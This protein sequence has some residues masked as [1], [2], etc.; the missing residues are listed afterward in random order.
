MFHCNQFLVQ[1]KRN[2]TFIEVIQHHVVYSNLTT[3]GVSVLKYTM[4]IGLHHV[5]NKLNIN[6]N[7]ANALDNL[8]YYMYKTSSVFTDCTLSRLCEIQIKNAIA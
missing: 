7:F 5:P 4:V 3:N 1:I 2:D 6:P 8:H